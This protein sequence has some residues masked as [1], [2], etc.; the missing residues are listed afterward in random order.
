MIP[1]MI[2]ICKS[3]LPFFF[4]LPPFIVLSSAISQSP[5][6][7]VNTCSHVTS[8]L[9]VSVHRILNSQKYRHA[10]GIVHN[11]IHERAV[12]YHSIGFIP[13]N[14]CTFIHDHYSCRSLPE[15]SLPSARIQHIFQI[16]FLSA[17][18]YQS[19]IFSL[20][21]SHFAISLLYYWSFCFLYFDLL[22]RM[23]LL[24]FLSDDI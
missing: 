2:P 12:Q 24:T 20:L 13:L 8:T 23:E 14:G 1:K 4:S 15:A 11:G 18:S 21:F 9:T 5:W 17:F 10:T 3:R 6:K 22:I 7:T 19:L 16:Y